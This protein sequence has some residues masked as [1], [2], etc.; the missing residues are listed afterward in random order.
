MKKLFALLLVAASAN[1]FAMDAYV[2]NVTIG[3]LSVRGNAVLFSVNG[4]VP[5]DICNHWGTQFYIDTS[6]SNGK[7]L[8]AS[9]LAAK[10]SNAPLSLSYTVS[11]TPGVTNCPGE[12]MAKPWA[13]NIL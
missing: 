9:L 5:P 3:V 6:T 1:A 8:Y 7:N 10:L 2:P 13:I 11:T 12:A 4:A